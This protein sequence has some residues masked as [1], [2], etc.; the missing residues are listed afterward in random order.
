[1]PCVLS[2]PP[3]W[4]VEPYPKQYKCGRSS[5]NSVVLTLRKRK[6][7]ATPDY[8]I[9]ITNP[10]LFIYLGSPM[11]ITDSP[12]AAEIIYRNEGKY[13]SRGKSLEENM[14]W[15]HRK[16]NEDTLMPFE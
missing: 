6:G 13:P 1:M 2:A 14:Q 12:S 15:F 8:L 16:R 10:C 9:T 5:V 3:I 7:Q 11:V 4:Q